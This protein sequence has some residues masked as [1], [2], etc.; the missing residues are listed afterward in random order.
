MGSLEDKVARLSPEQ[1]SEA[2]TFIDFLLTKGGSASP[3][4]AHDPLLPSNHSSPVPPP[5]IMA[6]EIHAR[7]IITRSNDNLPS[8]GDLQ[9]PDMHGKDER[10]SQTHRSKQKDPGL[11]L[12]WID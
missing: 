3:G 10:V 1:R 2:E 11:L 12:D 5:I 6:E 9:T 7:P 8:L 4:P